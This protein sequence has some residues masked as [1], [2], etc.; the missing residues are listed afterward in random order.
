MFVLIIELR[1]VIKEKEFAAYNLA[2]TYSQELLNNGLANYLEVL[3]AQEKSL[4][5]QLGLINS[6]YNQLKYT[7]DLYKALG[8]G[9][10]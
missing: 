6:Q 1:L 4:S 10:R 3:T 9:W 8:G 5:S 2:S 7:I